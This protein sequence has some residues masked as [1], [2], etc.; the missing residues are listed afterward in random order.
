MQ[1]SVDPVYLAAATYMAEIGFTNKTEIARVL[2]IAMNPNSMFV[3]ASVNANARPLSVE[4]DM[5]PV[6]EFLQSKGLKAADIIKVGR[7][8]ITTGYV[9]FSG[10]RVG[11]G[12]EHILG[13]QR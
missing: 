9:G 8:L 4:G 3:Q 5:R 10:V 6:V 7:W 12:G 13:E 11:C 1:G 2:D